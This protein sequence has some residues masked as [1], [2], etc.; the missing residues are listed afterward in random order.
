MGCGGGSDQ[1]DSL[2]DPSIRKGNV[3]ASNDR[4]SV[5]LCIFRLDPNLSNPRVGGSNP[6]GRVGRVSF[7]WNASVFI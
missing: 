1:L 5:Y 6:P 3:R 2:I 7:T 4:P